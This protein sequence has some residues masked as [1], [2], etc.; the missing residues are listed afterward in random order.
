MKLRPGCRI[1]MGPDCGPSAV[2]SFEQSFETKRAVKGVKPMFQQLTPTT[3]PL[4][5]EGPNL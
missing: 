4:Q 1:V 3:A 2:L 5:T